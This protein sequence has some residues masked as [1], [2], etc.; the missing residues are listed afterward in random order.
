[1]QK[2]TLTDAQLRAMRCD[3]RNETKPYK[4]IA[5]G[6]LQPLRFEKERDALAFFKSFNGRCLVSYNTNYSVH[7]IAYK[8]N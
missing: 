4:V 6:E 5:A 3:K 7:F 8:F 2:N 1:M